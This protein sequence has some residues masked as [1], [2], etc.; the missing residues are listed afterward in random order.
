M[1]VQ[2]V[3][4]TRSGGFAGITITTE[5][6]DPDEAERLTEAIRAAVDH[7]SGSARD[8]FVYEFTIVTSST[9]DRI[10]M[11]GAQLPPGLR[12]ELRSLFQRRT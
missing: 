4:V 8:D 2:R 9:T 7:P 3:V 10:E 12:P 11:T 6:D 1:S 5:V